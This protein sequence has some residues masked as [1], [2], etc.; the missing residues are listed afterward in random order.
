M[1]PPETLNPDVEAKFANCTVLRETKWLANAVIREYLTKA[2]ASG[3]FTPAPRPKVAG[4]GLESI[5]AGLKQLKSGVSAAK[6]VV[7]L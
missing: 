4:H 5:D 1:V 3:S 2:M 6:L 7:T